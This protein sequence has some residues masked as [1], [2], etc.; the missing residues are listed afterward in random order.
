MTNGNCSRRGSAHRVPSPSGDSATQP[1]NQPGSDAT[2]RTSLSPRVPLEAPTSSLHVE[3]HTPR[4][5]PSR[6]CT[7]KMPW[8][9]SN[10]FCAWGIARRGLTSSYLHLQHDPVRHANE[11]ALLPKCVTPPQWPLLLNE[12]RWTRCTSDTRN[13]R[14]VALRC[15][16]AAVTGDCCSRTTKSKF[17]F[18]ERQRVF[19]GLSIRYD[20]RSEKRKLQM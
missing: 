17:F 11:D 7:R 19:T 13:N 12:L 10:R 20:K 5:R 8:Q 18:F 9:D 1:K 6:V 4:L 3:Y 15:H 14:R 2:K 16:A